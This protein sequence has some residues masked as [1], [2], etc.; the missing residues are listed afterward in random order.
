M[1]RIH[2]LLMTSLLLITPALAQES[3]KVSDEA[4][5]RGVIQ[6]YFDG[7]SKDDVESMKK[8][9]HPKAKYFVIR[10]GGLEEVSQERVY[11]NMKD[12]ARRQAGKDTAPKRIVSIDLTGDAAIAKVEMDYSNGRFTEYLSLV[13]FDDGWKIVSKVMS[14]AQSQVALK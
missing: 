14:G 10:Y 7:I 6:Y 13:K 12:N 9:F 2:L 3:A 8:A 11:L 1:S 5:I 4:A